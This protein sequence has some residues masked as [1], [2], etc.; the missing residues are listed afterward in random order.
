L[1]NYTLRIGNIIKNTVNR[2]LQEIRRRGLN[3]GTCYSKFIEE[4][5]LRIGFGQ[6]Y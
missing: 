6:E 2:T 1:L 5:E 3:I 4:K